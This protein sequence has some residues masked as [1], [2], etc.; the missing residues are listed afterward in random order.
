MLT[1]FILPVGSTVSQV[2]EL[3]Q[4]MIDTLKPDLNVD[5]IAGGMSGHH[6]PMSQ[7]MRTK[8]RKERGTSFFVYDLVTSSLIHSFDSIQHAVDN[9]GIHRA[10]INSCLESGGTL[11]YMGRFIFST[12]PIDTFQHDLS[13]SL[14]TLQRFFNEVRV[15]WA[16]MRPTS[17]GLLAENVL[18][19][20]LSATYSGISEF[21][22]A[23]KGDRATIRKYLNGAKPA[24]YRNQWKLTQ[25]P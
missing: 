25:L 19:P 7:A 8:L 6:E 20:H 23:T 4:F 12:E 13:L 14:E 18:H 24:L 2:L 9:L 22:R 5:P 1:Y 15:T 21:S 10:T 16:P 11:S 17:R 3:E